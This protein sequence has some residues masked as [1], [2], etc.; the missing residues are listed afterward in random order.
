MLFSLL[1][2]QALPAWAD[3]NAPVAPDCPG[4]SFNLP[5]EEVGPPGDVR[6]SVMLDL[7]AFGEKRVML[8]TGAS[9]NVVVVEASGKLAPIGQRFE[10]WG[11]LYSSRLKSGFDLYSVPAPGKVLARML[12]RDLDRF[13]V[14]PRLINEAGFTVMDLKHQRLLGFQ[15]EE[16]LRRCYE[17]G[18]TFK[19]Y[20]GDIDKYSYFFV[21]AVLD[22]QVA[23]W[24]DLD[25]G[26]GMTEFY[27]SRVSTAGAKPMPT[28]GY[29]TIDGVWVEP[30]TAPGHS[31]TIGTHILRPK[32]VSVPVGSTATQDDHIASLGY[33][34]L[35]DKIIVIPPRSAGYWEMIF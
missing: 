28:V 3:D 1:L 4:A 19:F 33:D 23:G 30:S 20:A 32:L 25:T 17:P 31:I 34:D 10:K 7:G 12:Y 5:I 16:D 24:V 35:H 11:R 8:D 15:K 27:S 18:V 29:V 21:H 9:F 26:R 2:P 22:G 13:I 6:P 14:N